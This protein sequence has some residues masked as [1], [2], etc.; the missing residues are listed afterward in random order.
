MKIQFGKWWQLGNCG[1]LIGNDG[2]LFGDGGNLLGD[3]DG[4]GVILI[5]CSKVLNF[6]L[7]WKIHIAI[8]Y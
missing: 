4:D 6:N 8:V 7:S 3:G 2:N 1:K 5:V